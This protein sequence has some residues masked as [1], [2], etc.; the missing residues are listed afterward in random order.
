ME[1][2]HLVTVDFVHEENFVLYPTLLVENELRV[3]RQSKDFSQ[4]QL[5]IYS[6]DGQPVY[7]IT[8]GESDHFAIDIPDL[9][10]GYYIVKIV[11]ENNIFQKML[12]KSN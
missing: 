9:K 10:M 11:T 3:V 5:T 12:L 4:A 8:L 6:I 7:N 2:S 1:Y